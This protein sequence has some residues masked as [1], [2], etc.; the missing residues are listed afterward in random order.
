MTTIPEV[1]PRS[2]RELKRPFVVLVRR[3]DPTGE[4]LT[5]WEPL[6]RDADGRPEFLSLVKAKAAALNPSPDAG[7]RVG[8]L[9]TAVLVEFVTD[10]DNRA[11]SL[12]VVTPDGIKAAPGVP[13]D[14]GKKIAWTGVWGQSPCAMLAASASVDRRRLV[15][16][17]CDCAETVLHLVPTGKERPRIALETARS[18]CLGRATRKEAKKAAEDARR[19]YDGMI[20]AG[21]NEAYAAAYAAFNAVS[22]NDDARFSAG[23]AVSWL[24]G[25]LPGYSLYYLKPSIDWLIM[26]SAREMASPGYLRRT[27]KKR[28]TEYG[29]RKMDLLGIGQTAIK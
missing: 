23:K 15:L 16:A 10:V 1:A 14:L 6:V 28:F 9:I 8:D 19:A 29:Q 24:S 27:E 5:R 12:F 18:W 11:H 13:R 3:F 2:P 7:L 26:N 22:G 25:N 17:A 4:E 21:A 20:F